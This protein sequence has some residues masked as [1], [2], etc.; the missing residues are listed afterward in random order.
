[1]WT[2]LTCG[3]SL[4]SVSLIVAIIDLIISSVMSTL[5]KKKKKAGLLLQTLNFSGF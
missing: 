5:K 2:S 3:A 1:M 4:L